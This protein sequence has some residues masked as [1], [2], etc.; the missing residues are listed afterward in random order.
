MP[1]RIILVED[2]DVVRQGVRS[3]LESEPDIEVV[4]EASNGLEAIEHC[5]SGNIDL[6]VMDMN[7]P[8]MNGV[9]CTR[10]LK[11]DFPHMKVLMLSMHDYEHYLIDM[12]QAGANG[13][14]LKSSCRDELAFAIKK[15]AGGGTYIGPE[16]TL[17]ILEKYKNGISF[18]NYRGPVISSAENQVLELIAEGYTNTQI[19]NKLFTSIRTIESRRKKL[20]E[21][22][23]TTNTATLIKFSF[24]HG[25][26][27]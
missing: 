18:Q 6:A 12:L 13:Y 10:V 16:F 23:G 15:I 20:L 3:L 4:A 11:R 9:E 5:K 26:V 22:T 17:S 8:L 2:H 19:A 1:V 27:K 25:L 7:M 14:I 24:K 21:K